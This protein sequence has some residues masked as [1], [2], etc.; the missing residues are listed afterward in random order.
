MQTT[1][2]C[3]IQLSPGE[4]LLFQTTLHWII[5]IF[6]A[7]AAISGI[8]MVVAQG[9]AQGL[10]I[11]L[12]S[13]V[14]GLMVLNDYRETVF[15]V[16]SHRLYAHWRPMN[17]LR[18]RSLD[19]RARQIESVSQLNHLLG[20]IMG[21][22]GDGC[23]AM[24]VKGTGS[25]SVRI[26]LVFQP[27]QFKTALDSALRVIDDGVRQAD[28]T[29]QATA[30]AMVAIQGALKCGKCA[31][32]SPAGTAFCGACGTKLAKDCPK[33]GVPVSSAF[34]SACGTATA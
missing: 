3:R 18:H 6:P 31:Q 10:P 23:A 32:V 28:L 30:N 22:F 4:H 34:C 19:M 9:V 20:S 1:T 26:D 11:L 21:L 12:I 25:S 17:A 8:Y 7:A 5:F 16:T 15:I 33:C 24:I 29:G 27:K 14:I 2:E 13:L